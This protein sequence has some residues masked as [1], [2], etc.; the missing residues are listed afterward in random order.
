MSLGKKVL[1]K[2]GAIGKALV[3][4]LYFI[5]ADGAVY[6]SFAFF[7]ID[8]NIYKGVFTLCSSILVFIVMLV[9]S[10]LLSL[11]R[12]PLIKIKKL[13]PNQVICLVVIALGMLGFVTLYII[14]ADRI[15][16]Y[17]ESL[18]NV[19]DEYRESVDR[20][21]DTP[22]VIV[23]AWDTVIYV[24]TLCF[25]IPVTEEMTFRGVIYGQLRREF[26]PW[27]SVFISALFFGILHGI[28]VHIGYAIMCG[29]VIAACYHLTDSILAPILLHCI[30]NVFGS[31]IATFMSFEAFGIPDKVRS[32]YMLGTNLLSMLMMPVAVIA[33]AFLVSIKRKKEKALI[34]LEETSEVQVELTEETTVP[35]NEETE[36]TAEVEAKE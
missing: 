21:S 29:I 18:K 13:D 19:M 24:L 33:F 20:F 11:K 35:V 2:L 8:R 14:V 32:D 31:G 6:Y 22:Q 5:C 17:L 9:I 1:S 16:A 34:K 30:F 26:G 27:V 28:S 23:P 7:G 3:W 36:T 15:A 25:V 4:L 12:E 10:K